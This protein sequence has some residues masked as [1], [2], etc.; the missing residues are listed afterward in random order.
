M[1]IKQFAAATML[2]NYTTD[3]FT[4]LV[5]LLNFIETN[6]TIG[7]GMRWLDR[8]EAFLH[9][10]FL[11]AEYIKLCNNSIFYNLSLRC[12]YY[13]DCLIAFS[14]EE[15]PVIIEAIVHKSRIID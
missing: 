9:K 1:P 15:Q 4:S 8:Y 7:A 5:K 13:N 2:I 6:K 10:K 12:I 3:T 11:N 14:V